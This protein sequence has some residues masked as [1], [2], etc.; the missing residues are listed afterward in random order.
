MT[1]LLHDAFAVVHNQTAFDV[2]HVW[3]DDPIAA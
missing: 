3:R 1:K 2:N